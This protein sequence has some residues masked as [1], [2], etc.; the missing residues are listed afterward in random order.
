MRQ[1][2][3]HCLLTC[4][5]YTQTSI[6]HPDES[7]KTIIFELLLIVWIIIKLQ[8]N[9]SGQSA[10]LSLLSVSFFSIYGAEKHDS[11]FTKTI[12][13]TIMEVKERRPYS[14]LSKSRRHKEGPYT[15][16]M[17]G[18]LLIRSLITCP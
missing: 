3:D 8:M 4:D 2:S 13:R 16:E 11:M 6:Q 14:S 1:L 10:F 12:S 18:P 7:C 9:F 5:F 17:L 15:G